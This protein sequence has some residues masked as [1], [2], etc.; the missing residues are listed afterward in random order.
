MLVN[1]FNDT[2]M[3]IG[4]TVRVHTNVIE[5]AKT[6][7][8]IFEGIIIRFAGRMENKTFTVR[9]VGTSGIGVER[10]WP[11]NGR[12]IVKVEVKKSAKNARRSKLYFLRERTGRLATTV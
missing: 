2:E 6:R 4:D 7:V 11:L 3:R 8:Q 5:G 10:I 1:K 12:S 9:R